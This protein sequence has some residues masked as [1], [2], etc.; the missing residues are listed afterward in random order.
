MINTDAPVVD[1]DDELTRVRSP[2]RWRRPA[3]AKRLLAIST[4]CVLMSACG[5]GGGGSDAPVVTPPPAPAELA[6]DDGN[7]D[8]KEWK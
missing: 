5:G 2:D 7:W 4:V 1:L 6:W 3:A 8:Q